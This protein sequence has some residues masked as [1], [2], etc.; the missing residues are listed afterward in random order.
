MKQEHLLA[1]CFTC[2][3]KI[4]EQE[5]LAGTSSSIEIELPRRADLLAD[6]QGEN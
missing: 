3:R 4:V 1:L 2:F 6:M 5:I